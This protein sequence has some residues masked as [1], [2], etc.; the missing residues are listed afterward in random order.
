M[1]TILSCSVYSEPYF[2][3]DTSFFRGMNWIDKRNIGH[4]SLRILFR[5]TCVVISKRSQNKTDFIKC[6]NKQTNIELH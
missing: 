2:F 5:L 4:C 3:S 1:E 6:I